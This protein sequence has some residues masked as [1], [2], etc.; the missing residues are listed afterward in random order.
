MELLLKYLPH[1]IPQ[2]LIHYGSL[3]GLI[4]S[5]TSDMSL[6]SQDAAS[7]ETVSVTDQSL[8]ESLNGVTYKRAFGEVVNLA[9]N[10]VYWMRV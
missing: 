9:M 10:E 4:S 5:H 1:Q 8:F 3:A 6:G 7:M 2:E